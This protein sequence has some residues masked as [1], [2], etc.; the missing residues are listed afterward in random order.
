MPISCLVLDGQVA[1]AI[2]NGKSGYGK[3]YEV[4]TLI[5]EPRSGFSDVDLDF[6]ALWSSLQAPFLLIPSKLPSLLTQCKAGV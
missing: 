5:A 3:A 4:A 1:P 2:S 6:G